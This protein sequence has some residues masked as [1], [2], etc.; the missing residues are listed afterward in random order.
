MKK[1][2]IAII[3]AVAVS[4]GIYC[5]DFNTEY[6]LTEY[7]NG[8]IYGT[9][10]NVQYTADV[11]AEQTLN[12]YFSA[13][14]S[15][16]EKSIYNRI[17]KGVLNHKDIIPVGFTNEEETQRLFE[18]YEM[19]LAEHPEL[20]WVQR[21]VSYNSS[22]YLSIKYTLTKE[23]AVIEARADEFLSGLNGTPYEKSVAIFDWVVKSCEYDFDR[24]DE[25]GK[26]PSISNIDGVL[27]DGKAI[28]GGYARAYQYLLQKAGIGAL[29]ITGETKVEEKWI[30]HAWTCQQIGDKYYYSDPTWCDCFEKETINGLVSHMFFCVSETEISKTHK[31]NEKYAG[32]ATNDSNASY[33]K[34][35]GLYFD[36]YNSGEI[37]AAIAKSIT[38]NPVGIELKFADS[39]VLADAKKHLID[40]DEIHIILASIDLFGKNIDPRR[41]GYVVE[42]NKNVIVIIFE[43]QN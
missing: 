39:A 11:T 28:C 1:A 29:Y 37:R 25:A 14:L 43:K 5:Y 7:V 8:I 34:I 26:Y 23:Q 38:H 9:N 10:D 42:E 27:L 15:E 3:V 22:G 35:N 17:Y 32:I 40:Y 2:F 21:T 18:I 30:G 41:I 31:A 12:T 20:F 16:N 24:V 33:Y 19:V 36:K 6:S 4:F 13:T